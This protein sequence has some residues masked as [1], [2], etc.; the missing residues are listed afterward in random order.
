[1][2]TD[3][4]NNLRQIYKRILNKHER[5]YIENVVEIVDNVVTLKKVHLFYSAEIVR[6]LTGKNP[7]QLK[8]WIEWKKTG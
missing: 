1:M 6:K 3:K 2:N 5:G 8:K 4:R 7:K